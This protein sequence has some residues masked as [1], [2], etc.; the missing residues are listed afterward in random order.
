MAESYT[1]LGKRLPR[2]D[3]VAKVKGEITYLP[4]IQLPGMLHARFLRSP[5]AH[6]RIKRIDT[7]KAESLPG[8]RALL[9]HENA[10]EI[11]PLDKLE[12]LLC[13]TM[14]YSGDEVAVVAAETKAIAEQ[15]VRLI[16][17]EYEVLPAVF[18]AEEAMKPNAPLVHPEH[19]SNLFHGQPKCTEDGWF[20]V[21][22]GDVE[23]GFAEA[24][25][26]VENTF[27]TPKQYTCS[28]IPRAVLCQWQGDKL[29]CWAD[30]QTPMLTWFDLSRCLGIPQSDIRLI[31]HCVGSYG[32]KVPEKNSIIAALLARSTG[33]PVKI[34]YTREEDFLSVARRMDY[35][36]WGKIGVRN[37]G[38]IAAFSNR[39]ITNCGN[40][41]QAS[42]RVLATSATKTFI[43]LYR[44]PNVY[45][46]GCS[47]L[48]NTPHHGAML[49][50]G[51][52]EA[53]LCME[54]L[55]DEAAEAVGMDPTEFRQLNCVRY[56]DQAYDQNQLM[57]GQDPRRGIVGNDIDMG[58]CIRQVAQDSA[59]KEKWQGWKT[60]VSVD[61]SLRRGI[62]IATGMHHCSYTNYA[63][64]V[65]MNQDG[66]ANVLSGAVEIGQGCAT[67]MVQV[68]AET[69]GLEYGDISTTLADT[70]ATP[71]GWG[72]TG[73]M[74]T[75]SAVTAVK[76]AADDARKKLLE[77]AAVELGVEPSALTM[78][79]RKILVNAQP[80]KNISVAE[81]CR[82][83][84][85]IIGVGLN[86]HPDTIRDP[87]TGEVVMHYAAAGVVAE[88]EVDTS[89]G[90]IR[91]LKISSA[92]DCGK[93]INPAL[94]ENQIDLGVIM[95]NGWIRTEDFVIDESTGVMLNPNLLDYKL[96]TFLDAP[97]RDEI[98]KTILELPSAWGAYGA[99][100]FSETAMV[101]VAPA[102]ANAVYNAIGVRI[103]GDHCT[104]D[105]I[106]SALGKM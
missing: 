106:L 38:T 1:V 35:K 57:M 96:M 37:D 102:I 104:P 77:I 99:K 40:D 72:N 45:F 73:S 94:V 100:G 82:K 92:N 52:P 16:D 29:T 3:A 105:R 81:A 49:G 34:E 83:G 20:R 59:W 71:I 64:M 84:F 8:V 88:V 30:T 56:G 24:D 60:P 62:G 97:K 17:V 12:Y 50:F 6:A 95:G 43:M 22:F 5:H 4:D 32:C 41:S 42:L 65:R 46:E 103:R 74:G 28:P 61:A 44:C 21:G 19:G 90:E 33:R 51:D 78:K 85:Q 55:I 79:D 9:T 68:V 15:A 54:R 47:V 98:S 31:V 7:T 86:P 23:K 75:S 70:A 53:N 14:H 26:I 67:V 93:A 63:A 13:D 69:L 66:T 27:E 10:P 18:N 48:T 80:E 39:V 11:H 25:F 76:H 87:K 2:V 36:A 101:A 91:L 89:T 58:A